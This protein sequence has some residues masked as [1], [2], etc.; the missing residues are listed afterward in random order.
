MNNLI[1]K[2]IDIDIEKKDFSDNIF[3]TSDENIL[4]LKKEIKDIIIDFCNKNSINIEKQEYMIS[5]FIENSNNLYD[6]WYSLCTE[7]YFNFFGKYYFDKKYDMKELLKNNSENY[8]YS[9][10]KNT[11]LVCMH[12]FYNKVIPSGLNKYIEFY[13][14][15][16]QFLY[17]FDLT[18][19]T[20]L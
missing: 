11:L 8:E 7:K 16:K 17:H 6:G 20:S 1:I 14:A 4:A 10:D 5:G 15:P 2:K 9:V 19:W 12:H 13:I 3:D 18:K